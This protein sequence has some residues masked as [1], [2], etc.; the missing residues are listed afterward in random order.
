[1]K[2]TVVSIFA[3][4]FVLCAPLS[5]VE[6]GGVIKDDTGISTPEF[7]F[8]QSNSLALW[9]KTPLG[10]S[11][12]FSLSGE[13][14]YKYNLAVTK[15][16]SEFTNIADLTLFKLAG[17]INAGD[18]LINLSAGRF[19]VADATGAVF[20]QTSD[21]LSVVYSAA[22]IKAGLYAGYTGLLNA[23]NVTMA[24]APEKANKV[25]N[26]AYP[27]VPVGLTLELPSLF[28]NQNVTIQGYGLF[29]CGSLKTNKYYANLV[30]AGPFSNTVY[31][32]LSTSLGSNNFKDFMN[33]TGFTLY[34]FPTEEISV[35]AGVEYGSAAQGKLAAYSSVS[36]K[37][38]DISGKITP[39]LGFTY[40]NEVL[41]ADLGAKYI[42][43]HDGSK[44]A[45]AGAELA[46]SFVYN[47]FSDLQVGL[48]ASAFFDTTSA[49]A[50]TYNANL[51]LALA[52]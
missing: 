24:A 17:K 28:L 46:A 7:T 49:K 21:G 32:N 43:S 9:F 41:C 10:Q 33:Y 2:K 14:F 31:Y 48:S 1:M 22:T 44:Y 25:Y 34:V 3:A 12:A 16:G 29:D 52:F 50:N 45:G 26:L 37:G 38:A 20:A 51:N 18:G 13:G 19:S 40:G 11:K 4:L 39:K 36:S 23:L 42:L 6:W 47:I 8:N 15:A 30:I 5:A 35:N 27:Y